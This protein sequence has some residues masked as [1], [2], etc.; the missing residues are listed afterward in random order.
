MS[1]QETGYYDNFCIY[2]NGSGVY[3][4]WDEVL[5]DCTSCD[6]RGQWDDDER[7]GE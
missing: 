7:R 5:H 6:G 4:D 1:V 3:E 2:C